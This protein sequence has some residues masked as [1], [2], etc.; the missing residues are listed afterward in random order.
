MCGDEDN[1]TGSYVGAP[2][3]VDDIIDN[4]REDECLS[5]RK[6]EGSFFYENV[7]PMK[8]KMQSQIECRK[9]NNNP[10]AG[11]SY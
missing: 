1:M 3:P 6:N 5:E 2:V 7:V 9:P 4:F 8:I 10:I 11:R